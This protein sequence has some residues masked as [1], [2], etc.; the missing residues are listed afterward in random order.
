MKSL[1]ELKTRSLL[2]EMIKTNLKPILLL[3]FKV[4]KFLKFMNVQFLVVF[5]SLLLLFFSIPCFHSYF[6]IFV[7]AAL[8][9]HDE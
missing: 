2:L 3:V 9:N 5:I 4:V 1:K 8:L 6:K 7:K